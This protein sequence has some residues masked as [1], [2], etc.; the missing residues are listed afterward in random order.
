MDWIVYSPQ[1][2]FLYIYIKYKRILEDYRELKHF[3]FHNQGPALFD[4]IKVQPLIVDNLP[5]MLQ[6][7]LGYTGRDQ[8][9]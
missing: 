8:W 5:E 6:I 2:Q 1:T 7:V 9:N 3:A 4:I